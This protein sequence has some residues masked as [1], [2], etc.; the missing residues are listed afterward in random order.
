[1]SRVIENHETPL[2]PTDATQPSPNGFEIDNLYLDM[3]GII[4]PCCHPEGEKQPESEN[5]MMTIIMQYMDR[6]FKAVRP[7]K[8][9]YMAIDGVAPR[10]KMNQQRSR[11]YRSAREAEKNEQIKQAH[12]REYQERGLDVPEELTNESHWDSN[13]ITPGTPFMDKVATA[14]RIFIQAKITN[15]PAWKN[16]KVIFTDSNSPGEGEHKIVEYI[17][18]QRLQEEYNPNTSHCIHG[19]DADLIM[20]GLA[21]HEP[22]FYILRE[23]VFD[24]GRPVDLDKKKAGASVYEY[25]PLNFLH[26]SVLREY[27]REEFDLRDLSFPYDFERIIDD[28]IFL[29]FFVGNDF[30]PHL[31]SL[32]IREGALDM[33]VD[34]YK[35]Y[36]P[37][38]GGYIT[39]CGDVNIER[40]QYLLQ[41][42]GFK[43]DQIFVNR[44]RRKKVLDERQRQREAQKKKT[45]HKP[46]AP[47]SLIKIGDKKEKETAT[48]AGMSKAGTSDKPEHK[49]T[50]V[51]KGTTVTVRKRKRTETLEADLQKPAIGAEKRIEK[52]LTE[53]IPTKKQKLNTGEAK[54]TSHVNAEKLAEQKTTNGEG[55]EPDEEAVAEFEDEAT[56][57]QHENVIFDEEDEADK[58][59]ISPDFPAEVLSVPEVP[60]LMK[61]NAKQSKEFMEDLKKKLQDSRVVDAAK[62]PDDVRFGELGW[63]ERYFKNKMDIDYDD[64]L[65]SPEL[66]DVLV[67]YFEGLVWV[68]KY[69]YEGCAS[70]SWFYPYHYAPFASDLAR[71]KNV[72]IKFDRGTPFKPFTQLLAVFPKASAHAVPD[73]FKKI[74]DEPDLQEFY[75][76]D[77][78]IDLNGKRFEWMGV[79]LLPFIDEKR[80]IRAISDVEDT[81]TEEEKERNSFRPMTLYVHGEHPA[82]NEI[83]KCYDEKEPIEKIV[84]PKTLDI[85]GTIKALPKKMY[86]EYGKELE[87]LDLYQDILGV[88]KENLARSAGFEVPESEKKH[89]CQLLYGLQFPPSFLPVFRQLGVEGDIDQTALVYKKD[90]KG[91]KQLVLTQSRSRSE[92]ESRRGAPRHFKPR[93]HD[94]R[95]NS[96]HGAHKSNTSYGSGQQQ[97]GSYQQPPYN[98]APPQGY[99]QYGGF[100]QQNYGGY[101]PQ[102]PQYAQGY[103]P[104]AGYGQPG[105]YGGQQ[106]YGAPPQA[107]G[108]HQQGHPP[109]YQQYPPQ[110]GR[111]NQQYGRR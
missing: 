39:D 28:Y 102:N 18:L 11:R 104:A 94:N 82:A 95:Q 66:N 37:F 96:G 29:C 77:F 81:L 67:S 72:T 45:H 19:L 107:F 3:N 70:W 65:K 87:M 32:D 108:G 43:E 69:Y 10:A 79:A 59:D 64:K 109:Q 5:E 99:G 63:K 60:E 49:L 98:A 21:T 62:H 47:E 90:I 50:N 92:P 51:P 71:V 22:H 52:E 12:I 106:G 17:R 46:P 38:M 26:I 110:G 100:Q 56:L 93:H 80:L 25:K 14:L 57:E 54:D 20:L 1:M 61:P 58:E 78:R 42:I 27:L 85:R 16:I 86:F 2:N 73:Q 24:K 44:M 23:Q 97:R 34:L 33:I 111:Y 15:D 103:P 36:L 89:L 105:F 55:A 76:E 68:L 30:L 35:R 48:S 74:M 13:V 8:L 7:R 41:H 40:A 31:P 83:E 9:L 88:V 6:I 101:S 4:H 75:P 53:E 84:L 91:A